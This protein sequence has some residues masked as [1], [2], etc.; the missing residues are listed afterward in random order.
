MATQPEHII[1]TGGSWAKDPKKPESVPHVELGYNVT[2]DDAQRTLAG[3]LKT[4]GFSLLKAPKDGK[5]PCRLS[6]VLRLSL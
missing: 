1:A 6:S 5:L 3:L 2:D 4:P